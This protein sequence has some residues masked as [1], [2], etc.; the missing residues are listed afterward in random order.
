MS[1]IMTPDNILAALEN[2]K[3][4]LPSLIGQEAWATIK[5]DFYALKLR[6]QDSNDSEERDR[7][8]S[9][10]VDFLVPY[11]HVRDRGICRKDGFEPLAKWM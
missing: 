1:S 9:E 11:K 2:M 10:L 3:G 4:E 5:D 6:L 7:L 8:A